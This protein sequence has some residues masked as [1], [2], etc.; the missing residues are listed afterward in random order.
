VQMFLT[1]ML[2]MTNKSR[3][4]DTG[5]KTSIKRSITLSL[6]PLIP[7]QLRR[8]LRYVQTKV[9]E[10]Y[11]LYQT[12][13]PLTLFITFNL[14][15]LNGRNFRK[16]YKDEIIQFDSL[17][18]SLEISNDWFSPHIPF[19]LS[20]IDE[21][22]LNRKNIKALEIG[23]WEGLSSF[24]ILSA[25]PNSHLT[26]V[27]TWDGGDEHKNG[28]HNSIDVLNKIENRFDANLTAFTKRL[29]KYKGTSYSFFDKYAVKDF[30]DFIYVD[31]SHYCDDVNIDAIKCFEM[32]KIGGVM[33]FDDYF[34]RYYPKAIDNPAAPINLFLR[35]KHGSFKIVRHYYQ[36]AIVK[37]ASRHA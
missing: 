21:F 16:K 12:Y 17:K 33:I 23:S 25:M 30:Y 8:L 31:G 20:I 24:F 18:N 11:Y 36:I 22:D 4:I 15:I 1:L 34:W 28:T 19:W 2:S 35:L 5:K 13:A 3:E 27:D 7:R 10:N 26:C 6:K 14:K 37:T 29:S 32:L 9:I